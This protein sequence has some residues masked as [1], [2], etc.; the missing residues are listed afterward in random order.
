MFQSIRASELVGVNCI[1]PSILIAR[2]LSL[3]ANEYVSY[4]AFVLCTTA[5]GSHMNN[6]GYADVQNSLQE[7]HMQ[8]YVVKLNADAKTLLS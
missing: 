3:M 6:I 5:Q 1:C 4:L 8:F 2:H 7:Q